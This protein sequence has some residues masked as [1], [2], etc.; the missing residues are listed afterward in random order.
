M[1]TT[2][3]QWVLGTYVDSTLTNFGGI[4]YGTKIARNATN[5]KEPG[6]G[7]RKLAS[8]DTSGVYYVIDFKLKVTNLSTFII[9][10]C[11]VTAEGALPS[12][13]LYGYDG[14]TKKGFT[15]CLVNT[16][17]LSVGQTGALTADIQVIALATEDKD[18]TTPLPTEAPMTKA[19]VTTLSV[20]GTSIV[21]W[22][23]LSFSINNN[24]E[25]IATGNGV[26]MTEIY[27]QQ[28]EYDGDL[29]FA[30]TAELTYGYST[31]VTKDIIITLTDNQSSPST[32]TFTFDDARANS[33]EYSVDELKLTYE[34]IT[35]DGDELAI[36]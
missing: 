26:A 14:I 18:L 34:S 20:G 21:K 31:D 7:Q 28:A 22:Q 11:F 13:N 27:A 16:C 23:K 4:P 30:K 35:W 15:G 10:K 32:K 24:V 2:G 8:I 3:K 17:K 1:S 25:V 5:T 6:S 33:N 36:T 19:A 12:F 9:G 29:T